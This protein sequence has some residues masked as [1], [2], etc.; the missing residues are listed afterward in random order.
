MHLWEMNDK[1]CVHSVPNSS[2][3]VRKPWNWC[4]SI[5]LPWFHLL[6]TLVGDDP[7]SSFLGSLPPKPSVFVAVFAVWVAV[8]KT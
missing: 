4:S 2:I 6:L 7:A 5:Q 1:S 8:G 3:S